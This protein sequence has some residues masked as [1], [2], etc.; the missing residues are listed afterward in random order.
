MLQS[1]R[2][3]SRW[4]LVVA[5]GLGTTWAGEPGRAPIKVEPRS[6][7]TIDLMAG[8]AERTGL[9]SDRPPER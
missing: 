2:S 9:A 8:F 5:V 3:V 4:V 7:E 6:Q 1:T